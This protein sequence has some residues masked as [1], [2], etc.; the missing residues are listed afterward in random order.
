MKKFLPVIAFIVVL[1]LWQGLIVLLD[2]PDYVLPTP[3][4]VLVALKE[5]CFSGQLLNNTVASLFRV[6]WGFYLAVV[7]GIPLGLFMGR[8]KVVRTAL[9]PFIQFLRPISPLAWI[10]MA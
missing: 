6:T 5:M 1:T 8:S 2:I 4:Q 7:T 3:W 9:N 10:P